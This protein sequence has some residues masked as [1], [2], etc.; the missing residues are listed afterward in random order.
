MGIL[1]IILIILI[2]WLL[3][4]WF[5]RLFGST[6][7]SLSNKSNGSA[8]SDSSAKRVVLYWADWCPHCKNFL[9]VWKQFEK[10]ARSF[11]LPVLIQT[12]DCVNSK[13]ECDNAKVHGFPTVRLY[14]PDG[15][16]IEY[17]GNRTLADVKSWVEKNK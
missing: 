10:E 14:N 3:F 7:E 15:S 6:Q 2:L 11:N 9:P 16:F 1:D 17:R 12:V 4:V 8:G 13:S 5:V